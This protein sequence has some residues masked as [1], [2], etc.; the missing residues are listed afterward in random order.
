MVLNR[1]KLT[2]EVWKDACMVNYR[3]VMLCDES[4]GDI[5]DAIHNPMVQLINVT[6]TRDHNVLFS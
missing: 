6:F 1:I 5:W 2:L 4:T 3:L